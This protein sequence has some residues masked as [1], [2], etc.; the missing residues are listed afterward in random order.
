MN[1]TKILKS[2]VVLEFILIILGLIVGFYLENSLPK[3][4]KNWLDSQTAL[5]MTTKD[6]FSLYWGLSFIITYL[7]SMIGLYLLKPWS[8]RLYIISTVGLFCIYPI[9]GPTVEHAASTLIN[10]MA[11]I[12]SGCIFALILFTPVLSKMKKSNQGSE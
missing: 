2:L 1:H 11:S 3:E 8:K 12:C 4:L 7:I 9:L 10:E 6:E 5:P